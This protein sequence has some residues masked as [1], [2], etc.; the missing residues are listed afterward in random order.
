[1]VLSDKPVRIPIRQ[2]GADE[3]GA[4]H[5][6]GEPPTMDEAHTAGGTEGAVRAKPASQT[7]AAQSDID[8]KDKAL[9]LQA[10]M[11]TYRQRQQRWAEEQVVE[12]K[13]ALLLSFLEVVDNLEQALKYLS[14]DDPTHQGVQL[15][16]DALLRMLMREG[17]ER[18]FAQG[19]PFDPD[20]HE[21]VA[22]VPASSHQGEDMR[23]IEVT[24]PGYRYK[25]RVLRPAKVIVAK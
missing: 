23:V 1:M 4:R 16:Y 7:A 25:D 14:A 8:W 5:A 17:V 24:Q 12:E 11:Q 20:V 22:V 13:S 6:V 2:I 19:R 10:E 18:I 21:A 9:R 15:A 3:A